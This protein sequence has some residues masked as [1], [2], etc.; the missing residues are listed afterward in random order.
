MQPRPKVGILG[1]ASQSPNQKAAR[2]ALREL[3]DLE[4]DEL[5][6]LVAPVLPLLCPAPL[7]RSFP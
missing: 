3:R 2:T 7:A 1:L 5:I 4:M 6:L